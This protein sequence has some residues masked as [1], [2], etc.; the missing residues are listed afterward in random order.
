MRYGWPSPSIP[1][2][3]PR[4]GARS[5]RC[6]T[7]SRRGG[8]EDAQLLVSELVT[9][10]IRHAGLERDDVITLVGRGRATARCGSR[11]ATPARASS[12]AS[13][14]P[15]PGR[16]VGLGP[17]PRARALRPLG[18]R[19]QRRDARLVR[20]RPRSGLLATASPRP[21]CATG[22]A[23][24]P[25]CRCRRSSPLTAA[26]LASSAA[27]RSGTLFGLRRLGLDGDLLA[28]RLA[29]DQLEHLLAVLVAVLLRLEV[30]RQRV[31]QLLGHLQLAVGDLE[32][33]RPRAG[34]RSGRAGRPRRRRSSSPSS[35]RRPAPGGSPR[36]APS[37][38]ARRARSATL[39]DSSIAMQQQPVGLR[40]ALVG[41]EVVRD[42]RSRPGRCRRGRRSPRCRSSGSS[43]G[44]APRA[45]RA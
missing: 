15:E 36:A 9:N 44:R 37:S 30:R 24:A 5:A 21:S 35:A 17:L 3:P 31:D 6:P 1:T 14:D 16:A 7:S 28:R 45:R 18:R 26:R 22:L 11:S 32:V 39:S 23:S 42:G 4:R 41:D 43:P 25:S 38:A 33:V 8:C 20:A 10:A 2:R 34:R 29:L 12:P 19:A 40:R 13:R 27:M